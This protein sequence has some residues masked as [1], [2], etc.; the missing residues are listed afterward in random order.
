MRFAL[1]SIAEALVEV[2]WLAVGAKKSNLPGERDELP[3]VAA[4]EAELRLQE[5]HREAFGGLGSSHLLED[6]REASRLNYVRKF[7]SHLSSSPI[8]A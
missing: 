4:S 3:I 1:L 5:V 8:S 2:R 7:R 6:F